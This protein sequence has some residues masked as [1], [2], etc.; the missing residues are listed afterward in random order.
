MSLYRDQNTTNE[1]SISNNSWDIDNYLF[2]NHNVLENRKTDL[3]RSKNSD[4][5]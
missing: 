2:P 5:N 4:K 1:D 3:L